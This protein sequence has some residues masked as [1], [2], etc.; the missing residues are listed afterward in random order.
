[1]EESEA[2]NKTPEEPCIECQLDKA[3]TAFAFAN[4]ACQ[5][6]DDPDSKESCVEWA[7]SL[8]P[9]N[10][11]ALAEIAN[12]TVRKAGVESLSR[13]A[14]EFNDMMHNAIVDVTKE[15]LDQ[16]VEVPDKEMRLYK[17][18]VAKRGV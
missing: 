17:Y 6:I 1:M 16:G 10:L 13:L 14:N 12:E 3:I 18:L 9:E 5:F 15:R 2:S 4:A 8:D 7:G 11:D